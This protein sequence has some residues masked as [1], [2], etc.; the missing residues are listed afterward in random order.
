MAKKKRYTEDQLEAAFDAGVGYGQD[1]TECADIVSGRC[2]RD[3]LRN[4]F[5]A[6]GDGADIFPDECL[7]ECWRSGSYDSYMNE[8]L[9]TLG[10]DD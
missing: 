4:G 8:C 6:T 10:E 5:D 2:T 1:L 9:A 7:D 3:C